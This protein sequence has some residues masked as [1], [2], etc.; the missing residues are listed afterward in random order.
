MH[1]YQGM[2]PHGLPLQP[3]LVGVGPGAPPVHGQIP[4]SMMMHQEGEMGAAGGGSS[5]RPGHY[6]AHNSAEGGAPRPSAAPN[7]NSGGSRQGQ[8]SAAGGNSGAQQPEGADVAGEGAAE[9]DSVQKGAADG[10]AGGA[11]ARNGKKQRG[12]GTIAAKKKVDKDA[13]KI[14]KRD[15]KSAREH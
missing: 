5:R 11:A 6:E 2:P 1:P 14:K 10:A 4:E 15:E 8:G 13:E 12:G 3:G 9:A 7:E